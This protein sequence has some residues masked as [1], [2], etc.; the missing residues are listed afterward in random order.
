M[1]SEKIYEESH[2]E[3][4]KLKRNIGTDQIVIDMKLLDGETK[5]RI[6]TELSKIISERSKE[7]ERVILGVKW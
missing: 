1:E 7:I 3:L 5:N 2:K 4:L 6:N